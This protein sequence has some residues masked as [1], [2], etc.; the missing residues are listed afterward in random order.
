MLP[1]HHHLAATG[2]AF[3]L[4]ACASEPSYPPPQTPAAHAGDIP[5]TLTRRQVEDGMRAV[6]P[7]VRACFHQRGAS[8]T[9][10]LNVT[11]PGTGD[12]G[13][14]SV[15]GE[16]ADTPLGDCAAAAARSASFPKF[17]GPPIRITYPFVVR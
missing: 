6:V 4:A 1:V 3:L 14:V 10:T 11:I 9:V 15:T 2:A 5:E 7:D 13:A 8:G 12:A 17:S 16:F